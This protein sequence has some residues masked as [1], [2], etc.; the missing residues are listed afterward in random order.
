MSRI[1]IGSLSTRYVIS[2]KNFRD[3]EEMAPGYLTAIM[4]LGYELKQSWERD[5]R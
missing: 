2:T 4:V 1:R 3:R 5:Q